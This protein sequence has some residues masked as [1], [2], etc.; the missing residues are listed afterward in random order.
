MPAIPLR[1]RTELTSSGVA[2]ATLIHDGK[3]ASPN[4]R[5]DTRIALHTTIGE[6]ST[7]SPRQPRASSHTRQLS[8][9]R[10]NTTSSST[11]DSNAN[12]TGIHAEAPARDRSLAAK[13]GS[14]GTSPKSRMPRIT[15]PRTNPKRPDQTT[16]LVASPRLGVRPAPAHENVAPRPN[17]L[18][19]ARPRAIAMMANTPATLNKTRFR[20]RAAASHSARIV[21]AVTEATALTG[22]APRG[23]STLMS[24]FRQLTLRLSC[25]AR[26]QPPSRRP[27]PARRQLQPVV[28]RR[29]H[30]CTLRAQVLVELI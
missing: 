26:T 17:R 9:R 12:A 28:R 16:R 2:W 29:G 6:A 25:G 18:A 11:E 8:R 23:T 13:A 4:A 20:G 30:C 1:T 14:K 22:T 15:T 3:C 5:D 24:L 21:T 19:A 10:R 27:P 7:T